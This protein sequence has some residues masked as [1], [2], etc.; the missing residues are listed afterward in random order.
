M[1][2]ADFDPFTD[3]RILDLE[4]EYRCSYFRDEKVI[5]LIE[6]LKQYRSEWDTLTGSSEE[7][8]TN[9]ED[10]VCTLGADVEHCANGGVFD[11]FAELK[12]ISRKHIE[13]MKTHVFEPMLRTIE[14]MQAEFKKI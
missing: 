12:K 6:V 13:A 5:E 9:V 11:D 14:F 4:L 1:A 7:V 10:Y 3:N 2:E 8:L